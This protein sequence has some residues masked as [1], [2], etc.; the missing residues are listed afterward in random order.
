MVIKCTRLQQL[1]ALNSKHENNI[2][3]IASKAESRA[4]SV[5]LACVKASVAGK[6]GDQ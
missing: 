4:E 3:T 5:K 2:R 6:S 1:I